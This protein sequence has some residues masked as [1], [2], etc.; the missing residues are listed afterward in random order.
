MEIRILDKY[1]T[2]CL[3]NGKSPNYV[4]FKP[5]NEA[6][7][8]TNSVS[9]EVFEAYVKYKD[10]S[11]VVTLNEFQVIK[12]FEEF[13]ADS[14]E[15]EEFGGEEETG[16]EGEGEEEETEGG[17]EAEA[18]EEIPGE[19]EAGAEAEAEAGAESEEEAEGEE[20]EA[21]ESEEEETEEDDVEEDK[22]TK[23]GK[24]TVQA[25]KAGKT[26]LHI[27]DGMKGKAL[28]NWLKKNAESIAAAATPANEEDEHE[29]NEPEEDN[30]NP[31]GYTGPAGESDDIED[32]E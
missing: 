1:I 8:N 30:P 20:H 15:E 24:V 2:E 27:P 3:Q 16:E 12:S 19:E 5:M 4:D 9:E 11:S 7:E 14:E 31:E 21:G 29:I 25:D 18:G 32:K 22:A 17:V 26:Q 10:G 6:A 23:V 28:I 13:L